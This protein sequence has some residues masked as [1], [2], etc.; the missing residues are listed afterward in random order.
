M[1][2]NKPERI[3]IETGANNDSN[4]EIISDKIQEGTLVIVGIRSKN[5]KS[6]NTGR[7]R[8]PRL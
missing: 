4:T 3:E 2:R 8:V 6:E 1:N 5:S 7:M